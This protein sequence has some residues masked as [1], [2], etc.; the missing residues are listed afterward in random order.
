MSSSDTTKKPAAMHWSELRTDQKNRKSL[1]NEQQ[2]AKRLELLTSNK[3][4]LLAFD[5]EQKKARMEFVAS[6]ARCVSQL[7]DTHSVDCQLQTDRLEE[8]KNQNKLVREQKKVDG[9]KEQLALIEQ[10]KEMRK[11]MR[12]Q[13][14]EA[15]PRGNKRNVPAMLSE[16]ND[17]CTSA[18][19]SKASEEKIKNILD[20]M[21]VMRAVE[22]INVCDENDVLDISA[23]SLVNYL[24]PTPIKRSQIFPMAPQEHND[25]FEFL[26]SPL[27]QSRSLSSVGHISETCHDEVTE[28]IC[29]TDKSKITPGQQPALVSHVSESS[30]EDSFSALDFERLVSSNY[31]TSTPIRP[32]KHQAPESPDMSSAASWNEACQ[33]YSHEEANE[34]EEESACRSVIDSLLTQV[35]NNVCSSNTAQ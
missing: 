17:A 34:E 2:R 26:A 27:S 18:K 23:F 15:K 33:A 25:S 21:E 30:A 3:L 6:Q 13:D 19:K 31:R 32:R 12:K 16:Q 1:L 22:Q 10:K 14:V 29:V 28:L 11:E 24:P 4:A 8:E 35:L 7:R 5:G 9:K 20:Q